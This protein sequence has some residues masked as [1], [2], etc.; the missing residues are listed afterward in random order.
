MTVYVV[1]AYRFGDRENH[2]YVV[3]V[4]STHALAMEASEIEQTWRGGN[5]YFCEVDE[6]TIDHIDNK[7][8]EWFRGCS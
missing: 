5:K 7:K 4:F 6:I 1:T 2:S 3:G 8:Q